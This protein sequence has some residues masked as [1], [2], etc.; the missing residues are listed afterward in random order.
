MNL[1]SFGLGALFF[2]LYFVLGLFLGGFALM[3][4]SDYQWWSFAIVIL[5]PAAL[6]WATVAAMRG[7]TR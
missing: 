3:W 2:V 5:M 6:A 4:G 7:R 1:R